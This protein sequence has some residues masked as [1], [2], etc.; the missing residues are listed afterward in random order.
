M[1]LFL[2]LANEY[3]RNPVSGT[4]QDNIT[5][6]STTLHPTVTP[7]KKD[8]G[9]CSVLSGKT[10]IVSDMKEKLPDSSVT[11]MTPLELFASGA[12]I[13]FSFYYRENS[14]D[15]ESI[16]P[17]MYFES[18]QPTMSA[19]SIHSMRKL[20]FSLFDF[21]MRT[22]S[23]PTKSTSLHLEKEAF[24]QCLIETSKGKRNPKTGLYQ[25]FM[26]LNIIIDEG[27]GSLDLNFGRPIS[28][29]VCLNIIANIE[30]FLANIDTSVN[31][32]DSRLKADSNETG[33]SL[34][35]DQKPP[36][37]LNTACFKTNRI[38]FRVS[39]SHSAVST[40]L[41]MAVRSVNGKAT[42]NPSLG[43]KA[44]KSGHTKFSV[45]GFQV[46]LHHGNRHCCLVT[47]CIFDF[48]CLAEFINHSGPR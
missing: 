35:D 12:K 46:S 28:I 2:R 43:D 37:G 8:S 6:V 45:D 19:S 33:K 11:E 21:S 10:T 42:F 29:N 20:D 39:A 31:A 24:S 23:V 14:E 32:T 38:M 7:E 3:S 16:V 13:S 22:A 48:E 44:L 9:I 5:T 36:I 47:L 25:E 40:V 15:H 18:V 34:V 1:N 17:F 27:S 26:T 4:P 41:E 30:N